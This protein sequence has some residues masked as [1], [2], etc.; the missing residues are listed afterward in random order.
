MSE[1]YVYI[2]YLINQSAGFVHEMRLVF[3]FITK[4]KLDRLNI[5]SVIISIILHSIF[6]GL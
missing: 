3:F 1:V 5:L 4:K 6:S 2:L